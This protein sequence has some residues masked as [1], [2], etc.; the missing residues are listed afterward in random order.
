[1]S[2]HLSR[3]SLSDEEIVDKLKE[4]GVKLDPLDEFELPR[5][6]LS[7]LT[8]N[9]TL[10]I[11]KSLLLEK[12]QEKIKKKTKK[13]DGKIKGLK[14]TSFPKGQSPDPST[15]KAEKLAMALNIAS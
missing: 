1:M 11:C 6:K 7:L 9:Y 13:K 12:D 4:L 5:F 10:L 15:P 2:S 3:N 8:L 14:S